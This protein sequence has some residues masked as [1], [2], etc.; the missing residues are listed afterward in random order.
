MYIQKKQLGEPNPLQRFACIHT[1]TYMHIHTYIYIRMCV[2][3]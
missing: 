1:Y 3:I 2:C